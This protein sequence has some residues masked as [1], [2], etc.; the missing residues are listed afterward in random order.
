[1][2]ALAGFAPAG[3]PG[4]AAQ[5]TSGRAISGLLAVGTLLFSAATALR[6]QDTRAYTYSVLHTF[7]G[8]PDGALP[9]AGLVRDNHGNLYGTTAWGGNSSAPPPSYCVGNGGCGAVFKLDRKGNETILYSFTGGTDGGGND[10]GISGLIRDEAGNLYGTTNAGGD[11]SACGI[12]CGV[13]FKVDPAGNE[14]VIN[15]KDGSGGAR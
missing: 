13:V 3:K 7:T 1:M 5:R 8:P 2:S 4:N 11:L 10:G 6:S 9:V 12:G 14:T 15:P